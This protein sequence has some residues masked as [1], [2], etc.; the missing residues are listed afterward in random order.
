MIKRKQLFPHKPDEGIWGDCL[1]T[2]LACLL[3]VEPDAVPHFNER[4]DGRDDQDVARLVNEWVGSKGLALISVF[5]NGETPLDDVLAAAAYGSFG[6]PFL[7]SG[8]SRS[9]CDHVVICKGSEIVWDPSQVDSG[10]IG[11]LKDGR[12]MIEWLVM[13]AKLEQAA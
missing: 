8:T 10:I 11:P 4:A 1:R 2:A 12:W 3:D 5:F 13:P 9:G 7:L 6:M